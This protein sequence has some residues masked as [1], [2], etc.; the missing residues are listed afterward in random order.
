MRITRTLQLL[1]MTLLAASCASAANGRNEPNTPLITAEDLANYP[2]EPVERILERKV[3]GLEALVT[4]SGALVLRIRGAA[5]LD[6]TYRPPLYIVNDLPVPPGPE[7]AL[8]GIHVND[9]ESI[10]I[11]RGPAAAIYGIDGANGA[12]LIKTKRGPTERQ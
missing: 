4:P 12:I 2:N 9:I 7:G 1:C 11:L 10:R 5:A 6:G 3:P 8:P